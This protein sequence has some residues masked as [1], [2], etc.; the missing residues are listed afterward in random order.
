MYFTINWN[1]NSTGILKSLLSCKCRKTMFSYYAFTEVGIHLFQWQ[2]LHIPP[3]VHFRLKWGAPASSR[4]F[5]KHVVCEGQTLSFSLWPADSMEL[6]FCSLQIP[7]Q[8]PLTY[9]LDNNDRTIQANVYIA[10]PQIC[11]HA[12]MHTCMHACTHRHTKYL[13]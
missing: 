13:L 10:M 9:F 4:T 6:H 1:C 3:Q 8:C 5:C 11:R 7:W 12:Y 2:F